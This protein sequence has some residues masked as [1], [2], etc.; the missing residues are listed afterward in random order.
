MC[1]FFLFLFW[2]VLLVGCIS[3]KFEGS[4]S[5]QTKRALQESFLFKSAD[6]FYPN[7]VP[8]DPADL[9]LLKKAQVR[10]IEDFL[11]AA[12]NAN[13]S[14]LGVIGENVYNR[15]PTRAL[16]AK[17]RASNTGFP[18]VSVNRNGVITVDTK[19]VQA[20]YRS[21]LASNL[22][23]AQA[24]D[25]FFGEIEA[26]SDR[27][28]IAE[29]LRIKKIVDETR[30]RSLIGDLSTG[31]EDD[32]WSVLTEAAFLTIDLE[33][34]FFGVLSF[35]LAHELAHVELG[36]IDL[37]DTEALTCKRLV[38]VE[39]EADEKALETTFFSA[40]A[41]LSPAGVFFFPDMFASRL[42][43]SD[44]F[45]LTYEYANFSGAGVRGCEYP[46]RE[47]RIAALEASFGRLTEKRA[48]SPL[49]ILEE[50]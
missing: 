43:A 29:F 18:V 33:Q 20:A 34:S 36:H 23:E 15:E 14:V 1:R 27:E 50:N 41:Q 3:V 13:Q 48:L 26:R 49:G 4:S 24:F 16:A 19:I 25:D 9:P 22:R 38:E 31:L 45:N 2:L 30:G 37:L 40:Q 6:I 44:F 8:D 21:A 28:V 10:E 5:G 12:L 42:G 17:I 46:S 7:G 32:S 35:M 11:K 39:L 47:A